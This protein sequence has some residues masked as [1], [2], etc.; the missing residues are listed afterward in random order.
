MHAVVMGYYYND[1]DDLYVL[2]FLI[3][4]IHLLPMKPTLTPSSKL[5][6]GM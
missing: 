4:F 5:P 3:T 1:A 6:H 2:L